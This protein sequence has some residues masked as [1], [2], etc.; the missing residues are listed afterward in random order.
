MKKNDNFYFLIKVLFK[1]RRNPGLVEVREWFEKYFLPRTSEF[2]D[3][4]KLVE[5]SAPKLF[6]SSGKTVAKGAEI[7]VA[8]AGAK[9]EFR[10]KVAEILLEGKRNIPWFGSFSI[11]TLQKENWIKL[12]KEGTFV[13]SQEKEGEE[14]E[15]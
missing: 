7:K 4:V 6:S 11:F 15:V 9:P 12:R 2:A 3:S 13:K 8:V 5:F 1:E 10:G 14:G